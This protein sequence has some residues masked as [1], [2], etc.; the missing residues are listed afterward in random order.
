MRTGM[1]Q[2]WA[3]LPFLLGLTAAPARA[4]IINLS[5]DDGGMLLLIDTQKA[6][7]SDK[8]P[9]QKTEITVPLQVTDTAYAWRENVGGVTADY[10][11][12]KTTRKVA[13]TAN[14]ETVNFSKPQCG[15]SARLVP[16]P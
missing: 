10:T 2:I 9:F 6:T 16:K 15:K 1:K 13:A 3:I 7:V 12:D 5:C 4:E 11:L 8:N 14:G